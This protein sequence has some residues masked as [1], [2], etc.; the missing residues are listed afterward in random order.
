MDTPV[1]ADRWATIYLLGTASQI[2]YET[3]EEAV[4][5]A[6]EWGCP[7][8][9]RAVH[10]DPEPVEPASYLSSVKALHPYG[11]ERLYQGRRALVLGWKL[12]GSVLA[13]YR[14]A[15]QSFH[16]DRLH[17]VEKGVSDE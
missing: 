2:T 7:W 3:R 9:A 5:A 12:D 1:V 10:S 13:E 15:V 16:P 8:V 6:L 17:T 4:S 11:S 14:G